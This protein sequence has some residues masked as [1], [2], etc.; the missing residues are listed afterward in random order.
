[1]VTFV[2]TNK[3]IAKLLGIK[4]LRQRNRLRGQLSEINGWRMRPDFPKFQKGK[5][6][7][8]AEVFQWSER[9]AQLVA[10]EKQRRAAV[11]QI[12][13][14]EKPSKAAIKALG[15]S[16]RGTRNAELS[17]GEEG[18]GV[19]PSRPVESI[20]QMA[21]VASRFFKRHITEQKIKVWLAGELPAGAPPFPLRDP[22]R[23]GWS[24][25][26]ACFEWMKNFYVNPTSADGGLGQEELF[27]KTRREAEMAELLTTLHEERTAKAIAD[28]K[29]REVSAKWILREVATGTATRAINDILH[30][31]EAEY[32]RNATLRRRERL[33]SL[34]AEVGSR[35]SEVGSLQSDIGPLTSDLLAQFC[36]WD[37]NDE[38]ERIDRIRAAC[39]GE[40]NQ[41]LTTECEP[42][43]Q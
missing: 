39:A 27:H 29:E 24:N 8:A 32:E 22:G 7:A 14:E 13:S 4:L 30:I 28:A 6:Y 1:M 26:S 12:L 37:A 35:K 11:S 23:N 9:F 42:H 21:V 31:V 17:T 3:D 5:G 18:N 34:L 25:P 19:D 33:A 20:R 10:P 43:R 2:K 38:R 41:N 15:N 40:A 36:Q 16:E